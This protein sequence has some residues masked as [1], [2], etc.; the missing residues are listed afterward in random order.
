M[1]IANIAHMHKF[2]DARIISPDAFTE[3]EKHYNAVKSYGEPS[4]HAMEADPRNIMPGAKCIIVLLK[5]YRPYCGWPQEN[6][7]IHPHYVSYNEAYFG[8]KAIA[9]LIREAGYSADASPHIPMRHAAFR[10][11]YGSSGVS[12]LL[13]HPEYGSYINFQTILTDMP[14]EI[15][16]HVTGEML[17]CSQCGK[18][19]AACPGGAVMGGGNI[20]RHQCLRNYFP[21]SGPVPEWARRKAGRMF[22][23]CGLCQ[24]ACPLNTKIK[25]VP[26]PDELVD[27]TRILDLLQYD[28]PV[29][30]EKLQKLK[31]LIGANEARSLRAAATAAIAAGNTK[32][33]AYAP[34]LMHMLKTHGNRYARISAAWALGR[35]GGFAGELEACLAEERDADAAHEIKNAIVAAQRI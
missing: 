2:N 18:C 3:W 15:T 33:P 25:P 19:A 34:A 31:N 6:V 9:S 16:H 4:R 23:G 22:I 5:A 32:N 17:S 30:R 24:S 14:L 7:E 11:G 12:G 35:I 13:M 8:A 29:F 10:A 26:P 20:A 21:C 1:D 28:K 27:C